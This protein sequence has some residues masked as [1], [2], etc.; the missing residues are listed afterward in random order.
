M[1]TLSESAVENLA[2]KLLEE[3]GY[4]RLSPE[5]QETERSSTSEVVLRACL[6]S[7]IE[8]LNPN[9]PDD[10]KEQALL[11]V[12][13]LSSQ[14]L[15]QNNETFQQMLTDGVGVEYQKKGNTVGDRVYLLDFENPQSNS[16]F[17]C[18]QF[19]VSENNVTKRPDVVLFVNGLPLVVIELKNPTDRKAMVSKAFTQLQNYKK[20]IPSLFHYNGVLVA[21]DGLD[22]KVGSLTA[23]WTR[24]MHWKTVDGIKEDKKNKR[25]NRTTR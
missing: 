23:G 2:I 11:E 18:N 4:V 1:T 14:S 20:A 19:T 22:A 12:L 21:S 15:I 9:V 24:F 5:R 17:V 25:K 16:L 10:A 13:N 6:Q 7:A 8:R 3:Q